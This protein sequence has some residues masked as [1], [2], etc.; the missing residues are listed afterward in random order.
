M[1][2][3]QVLSAKLINFIFAGVVTNWQ[4]THKNIDFLELV[5]FGGLTGISMCLWFTA[6]E[7]YVGIIDQS[8][9][10][11]IHSKEIF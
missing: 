1:P 4:R 5:D 6:S 3:I 11:F 2:R 9:Y 10:V 7:T 8:L